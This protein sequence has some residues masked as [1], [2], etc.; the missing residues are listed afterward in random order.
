MYKANLRHRGRELTVHFLV[1]HRRGHCSL[2][3][4]EF[5]SQGGEVDITSI[6]HNG[7]NITQDDPIW[8]QV[9]ARLTKLFDLYL[10]V[11]CLDE[12][13]EKRNILFG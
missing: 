5:S 10:C 12:L 4:P 9:D 7:V 1:D 2:C 3:G 13:A 8:S 6:V 11:D